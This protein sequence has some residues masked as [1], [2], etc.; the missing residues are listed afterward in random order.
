[1]ESEVL[2]RMH[3][4]CAKYMNNKSDY[5]RFSRHSTVAL[6]WPFRWNEMTV[7]AHHATTLRRHTFNS[8]DGILRVN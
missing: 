8:V 2:A 1:M 7:D 5:C 6:V 3:L 4:H